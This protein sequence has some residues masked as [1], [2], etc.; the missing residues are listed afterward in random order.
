M[1]RIGRK[2]VA[3]PKGVTVEIAKNNKITVKGPRGQL[4]RNFSSTLGIAEE[5]GEIVVTRPT[6]QRQ[7]RALHGLTRA[8]LQNMVTGVSDGYTKNLEL[9]GVGYRAA[10]QGNALEL[11]L[12]FSHPVVINPP[13]QISFEVDKAGRNISVNGIDKEQVGEVAAKLRALRKPEPYKGKGVRYRGEFV[14]SKAGKSAK[15]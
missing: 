4:T 9:V 6:D 10:M 1:S 3:I 12:G 11:S 14:R 2:P 13:D 7:V 8:L 5:N 15:R